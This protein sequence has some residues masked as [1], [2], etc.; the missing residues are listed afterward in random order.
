MAELGNNIGYQSEGDT[1]T[2]TDKIT[3][4]QSDDREEQNALIRPAVGSKNG[5]AEKCSM[6][7]DVK[8]SLDFALTKPSVGSSKKKCLI[9][10]KDRGYITVGGKVQYTEKCLILLGIDYAATKPSVSSGNDG[11]GNFMMMESDRE[12]ETAL[13]KSSVGGRIN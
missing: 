10:V 7:L 13:T 9:Q 2:N 6:L 1:N 8:D 12:C 3:S 11:K 4:L 5:S